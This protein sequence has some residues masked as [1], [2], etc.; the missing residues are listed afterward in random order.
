[1]GRARAGY[2]GSDGRKVKER[3]SAHHL[4]SQLDGPMRGITDR[5][6]WCGR[7]RARLGARE[8]TR[9]TDERRAA[10]FPHAS[11]S[12]PSAVV[13]HYKPRALFILPPSPP[14]NSP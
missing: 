14:R 4:S 10:R 6:R 2:E 11:S 5:P 1:M 3:G 8:W 13:L 12:F 7:C 9:A